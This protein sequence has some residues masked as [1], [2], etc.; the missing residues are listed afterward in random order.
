MI[1]VL[2]NLYFNNKEFIEDVGIC[3]LPLQKCYWR[4][5]TILIILYKL[6]GEIMTV[7]EYF[8]LVS[9]YMYWC[10]TEDYYP[11]CQKYYGYRCFD[12]TKMLGNWNKN[13]CSTVVRRTYKSLEFMRVLCEL[14]WFLFFSFLSS[15][16]HFS[17]K[18]SQLFEIWNSWTFLSR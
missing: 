6:F 16:F 11:D 1:K 3:T 13:K 2:I 7:T 12:V 10:V 5:Y 14:L 17:G 8:I 4:Y 18:L 15:G 9:H